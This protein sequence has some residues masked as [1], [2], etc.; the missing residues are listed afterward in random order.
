MSLI[1]MS[2]NAEPTTPPLGKVYIWYDETDNIFKFKDESGNPLPLIGNGIIS[3]TAAPTTEGVDGDYYIRTTTNFIYGPKAAG[4]WPS[5][6]SMVGPTGATGATG[7]TG[8]TGPAGSTGP[9]GADGQ[10]VPTGGTTG[11]LLAKI[12]ADDFNTEWVAPPTSAVW[13]AITGTLSD[14]TDLDTALSGKVSATSTANRFGYYNSSGDWTVSG[15]Y[16]PTTNGGF[17]SSQ[18][19]NPNNLTGYYNINE[20]SLILEPLQSSPDD[21]YSNT[22]IS[23]YLDNANSGFGIGTNGLAVRNINGYVKHWGTGNSGEIQMQVH[24][25]DLGNGTDPIDIKGLG[26][27]YGFGSIY[28]NV[29]FSAGVNGYT[30]QPNLQAG[31]TF[32]VGSGVTAF[33]DGFNAPSTVIQGYTSINVSPNVGTIS[34]NANFSALNVNP[35]VTT[36]AGN[37]NATLIGLF[38]NYGTF[39]QGFNGITLNPNITTCNYFTGYSMSPNVATL[40]QNADGL[41]INMDN[42]GLYAGVKASVTIQDIYFESVT[43]GTDFN[44]VN[45]EYTDTTTAGS[46]VATLVGY[47]IVVTI[48]SGVST[49]TQVLAA[50]NASF[51]IS[52]NLNI[53]ITGSGANPQTTQGP[54]NLA[55]GINPA[56]KRAAYFKGNVQIDGALSFTGALS[57]GALSSFAPYTVVDGGGNPGSANTL[58]CQPTVAASATIANADTLGLNTAALINIGANATV[59]TAFLGIAALGLPAVLSMGT[60]STVDRIAGSVFAVSLDASATGGTVNELAMCRSLALPNASTTVNRLYGYE[61]ALPFGSVATSQW[62]VYV[63][64]AVDNWFAGSVR[65][66]GT[67]IADDQTMSGYTFHNLGNTLLV[68]D[69]KHM[70][71]NLGFYGT[72]PVAQPTSSGAATAGGTYTATEQAMLQEVYDAVRTLGLMS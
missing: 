4:V 29:N 67:A 48:E 39:N 38:G 6:V 16:Q 27:C 24:G 52:S 53:S 12:D 44:S 56:S 36:F 31:V 37:A 20:N 54:T 70:T 49:A 60:G 65:I 10:G 35:N 59:T 61:M 69:L 72:T 8:P 46:E 64:A 7:A 15:N 63:S 13:G 21:A 51:P 55:G 68:G 33:N 58:I 19:I 11:Q 25:V 30:F 42:V 28:D 41:N 47:N 22:N 71:G 2:V 45:I 3:G 50:L 5:G 9:A 23:S 32:S 62:G 26:Y 66:G 40:M 34:N 18:V 17:S 1:R 43:A 14:Q 57:I